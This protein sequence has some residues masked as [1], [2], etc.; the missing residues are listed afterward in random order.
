MNDKE[1][2][3]GYRIHV[4]I[5]IRSFIKLIFP[6]LC[7][8]CN[9]VL[10]HNESQIC[11]ACL[12]YMPRTNYTK[13]IGN[14][15]AMLFWGR[16]YLSYATS[17]YH[18]TKGGRLQN[19]LHSLK[20][21]NQKHIG[22]MLGQLLGSDLKK[23]FFNTTDVIIPVPLHRKRLKSRGYN[24]SGL[25]AEG[26]SRSM[27]KPIDSSSCERVL[28]SETQTDKSRYERWQNV[29]DIFRIN[30][31]ELFKSKH[32]LIIDDV[33]TTGATLEACA[34]EFLKIPNVRVSI[35]TVAVA[36]MLM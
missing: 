33:V 10:F 25:I 24:Q 9:R 2:E 32:V 22:I 4:F 15:V 21:R 36:E 28:I 5:M 3:S 20:Y 23:S 35:A 19:M 16:A 1:Q 27:G 14:P 31:P 18:F 6:D 26:V 11:T 12:Y 7:P 29:E 34:V 13:E 17:L 8:G 30:E